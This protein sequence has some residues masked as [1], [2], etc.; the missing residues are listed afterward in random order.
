MSDDT[1][2]VCG[3]RPVRT[4]PWPR[5]PR[6][7]RST[8]EALTDVLESSRWALSGPFDGRVCYERRF[9]KAF[10]DFH[11]VPYCTP[12]SSGTAALTIAMQAL[13]VGRGDEV[14]VPGMTWVACASA[15]AN[16]GAMPVFV[17]IDPD[18]LAMSAAA[19]LAAL[20]SRTAAML[21]VHPYCSVADL[22]AFV[23]LASER[24]VALIEDCAQA[25]GARWRGRPVGTYGAAG[26]FSMQQSKLLTS[27]E[28]GAAITADETLHDRME[29]YRSD[30]RRFATEPALG[31]LELVEVATVQGRN[32]CLSEF[33]AAVLLDGL[34]RLD[35]ENE[36]R[37]DRAQH[38]RWLLE[39]VDGVS[40]LPPD[41]RVTFR[42]Y[43]NVVLRFDPEVFAGVGM[44]SLTRALAA[45]L[46]T[47]VSPMYVPM[48]RHPLLRPTLARLEGVP[49]ELPEAERAL[50][51]CATLTHP[52]L[53]DDPE[54][55]EDVVAALRKVQRRASELLRLPRETTRLSF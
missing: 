6:S 43:Y 26:C 50:R 42:T 48:N 19:A 30:G 23:A 8:L 13:G 46:G 55:M 14:L 20:T 52:V 21:V 32:L 15:V 16:L 37:A 12:T 25:H 24:G 2:V 36:V 9:A 7:E 53:L 17:D 41:P 28:G 44:E 39:T 5:W 18:T 45:E 29:Q 54:G 10:A 35:A 40:M 51:T 33:Q 38:L 47:M 31:R 22:D 11:G 3:G 27:G 1:L 49:A 34:G 4:R